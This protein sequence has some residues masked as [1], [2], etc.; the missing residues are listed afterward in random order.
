[1]AAL[2]GVARRTKGYA[3]TMVDYQAALKA[4]GITEAS[5]GD[6]V[7]FWTGWNNLWKDYSQAPEQREKANAEFHSGE[8]GVRPE[9]CDY[10]ATRK[11]AMM[12]SDPWG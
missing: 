3:I 6:V 12:G 4:Q 9:V 10:L 11:S 1:M 5:Q 7:L 2:K 8:P